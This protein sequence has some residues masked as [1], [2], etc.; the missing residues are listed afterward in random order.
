MIS[1][2][3][4]EEKLKKLGYSPIET[5]IILEK[6]DEHDLTYILKTD[7]NK[8][9]A[10]ILKEK[11][12]KKENFHVYL[13]ER[14]KSKL[15]INDV[16]FLVN[17]KDYDQ[18]KTYNKKMIAILKE[19]YYLSKNNERY[20][21][22]LLTSPNLTSK[23]IVENINV[24][25]DYPFY[26]NTK[27]TNEKKGFQILVNKY[28]QLSKNFK[29]VLVTQ[30]SRYGRSGVQ[31][32][33][34]AFEN[35]KK[36]FNAAKKEGLTLYVNSAYRSYEEQIEV[37]QDYEKRMNEKASLYAA[38]PGHSEHQTGLALDIFKPGSTT[39]TFEQTKEFKWLQ[40]HAHEYGFIL[41]YPKGKENITGYSYES[42]HYRYVGKK[43]STYIK[44]H[45]LTFDEYY[46]YF[47]D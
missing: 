11:Q 4:K 26:T 9:I 31:I 35:Y 33:K 5:K 12:F 39:K 1:F 34:D 8:D 40:D 6:L 14:K 10:S 23:Q 17:H 15:E 22:Y 7:Y 3:N 24:N 25:R 16:I 44:K 13:E 46:A 32:E 41:R 20:F 36:M 37:Y 45:D 19:E 38:K 43:V 28:Y 2:Q 30:S 18:T 29:P 42:W 21:N 27:Q 47:L